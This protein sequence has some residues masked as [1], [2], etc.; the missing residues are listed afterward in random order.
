MPP[1][2]VPEELP[3][4]AA[5]EFEQR[6]DALLA[7]VDVDQVVVYGDREH[8]ASLVFLCNLDP[9]FE[10]VLLVLGRGRRT[11]L[12]GK[13]DIGYVPVVPIEVDVILCPTLSLMGID[14]TGGP[15]VEQGLREPASVRATGS[16]SSAG[17]HSCR[18][19]GA[20]RS[21][22]SSRRR[23]SSTPCVRSP[24][25]P[26]SWSMSPQRSRARAPASA[27]SA[28]QT[29]SQYSNGERRAVPRT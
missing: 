13:E 12:V 20:G 14:R 6:I 4:I 27:P 2:D 1:L 22:R 11:L 3:A 17:R 26:S 16:A 9:R 7:A 23:S 24:A 5:S 15:T 18:R 25:A 19:S 28:P 8:A 29:R 10:E 21:R